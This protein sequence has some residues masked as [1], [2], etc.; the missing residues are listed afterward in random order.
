MKQLYLEKHGEQKGL[1]RFPLI[2][3]TWN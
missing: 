3:G 2:T 1:K